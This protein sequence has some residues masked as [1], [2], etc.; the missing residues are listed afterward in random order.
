LVVA[1]VSV[2][3]LA[4]SS[5]IDS[6]VRGSHFTGHASVSVAAI[7]GTAPAAEIAASRNDAFTAADFRVAAARG[8]LE[9]GRAADARTQLESALAFYR[10]V[11][12]TRW[13]REI[14]AMLT[15]A[16]VPLQARM[17]NGSGLPLHS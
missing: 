2:V 7:D 3:T 16:G 15:Q 17:P 6:A 10:S 13:I 8:L 14:E 11:E 12:A 9:D 4:A 1:A 5:P